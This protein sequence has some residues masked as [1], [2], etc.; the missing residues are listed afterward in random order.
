MTVQSSES[1]KATIRKAR[2]E[3]AES[4]GRICYDAFAAINAQHG[5]APD[6]PNAE[7]AAGLLSFLFSHPRFWCVVAEQ[8]GRIIGSNCVDE[9]SIVFGVGPIT[10]DPNVQ[11]AGVGRQL[12]DAVMTRAR[13]RGAPSVRLLQSAFHNRSLS[14]YTKLGFDAREPISVMQGPP[15]RKKIDG[16]TVRPA[17]AAD[18]E[19]AAAVCER[20]HGHNRSEEFSDGIRQGTAQVAECYGRI[21]GYTSGLGFMGHS[22]AES[23]RDLQALIGASEGFAGPGILVPTR[24]AELFRWCLE[25]G[26]RVVQ[27][28]TLM[29]T[30]LYSRPS[31]A[32]L[33]SVSF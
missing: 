27:P 29:S 7:I 17:T 31:G 24:N 1:T 15:L 3:D 22:V 20:V 9:R 12:M 5:Y 32:Y 25:N 23:N 26:L 16:Y 4:C 10:V 19:S 30:G 13:E 33:P 14:L 28:M 8:G 2:P 6:F 21:V 18:V 11:N